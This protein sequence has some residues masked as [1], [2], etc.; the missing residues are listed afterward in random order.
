M[1]VGII[2]GGVAGLAAAYRLAQRGHQV[3]VYEASPFLGG[4]VRTCEI[5]GERIE[6]FYHHLFNTDTTVIR[7]IEELGLGDRLAWIDSKVGFY[8]GGRVYDF[9]T[10]M[11]LLRFTPVSLIDR[12]R[13]G[14]MG[15]YLRRRKDYAEYERIT[16]QEWIIKFA[17]Q[18]NFDVVWGP[19]LR[20]KFG[21]QASSL[22]MV[23]LWNKIYLRFASRG[24]GPLQRE[25][26]GYLMGSFGVYID[27]LERRLRGLGVELHAGRPVEKILAEGGRV[28]GLRL[29]DGEAV[30]RDAVIAAVS[31]RAFEKIVAA[32]AGPTEPLLPADYMGKVK[33]VRWQWAMCLL[34]SLKRSLSHI[35]W[36]NISDADIPFI[37]AIEHTNFIGPERYGG[38]HVLY[39]SNYLEPSSPLL[40]MEIDELCDLYLPH[41]K[42]INPDFSPDWIVDRWLFKGPDAQPVFTCNY[43]EILPDHRTPLPGLYLANMS[44]IYP[45]DRGQNYS[46][47]MGEQVAE[48]VLVDVSS[49]AS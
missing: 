7:L 41:L 48:M 22:A 21:E 5:G 12:V 28:S 1:K 35:Y 30:P 45:E 8:H 20:G 40:Q 25:K 38:H 32:S 17:G 31:S 26:L 10:P 13:L 9:V 43:R 37:A 42:K 49:R 44:Q 36:L 27:E 2:G 16:A 15:V 47:R 14:L 6:S 18:R 46:I 33:S 11:D 29:A 4:L 19:L 39:L 3:A 24:G 23:W 34:L